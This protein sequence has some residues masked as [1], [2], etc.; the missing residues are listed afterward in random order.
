MKLATF[1]IEEHLFGVD[2]LLTREICPLQQMTQI[3]KAPE[4]IKGLM[5][6]RGQIITVIDP[7]PFLYR[8]DNQTH[9]DTQLLI[10]AGNE[11]IEQ[12]KKRQLVEDVELAG[13]PFAF[14]IDRI[15]NVIDLSEDRV[16]PAPASLDTLDRDLVQGVVE[17]GDDLVILLDMSQFVKR[18]L[19]V[20]ESGSR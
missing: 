8:K 3:A 20:S 19:S 16:L 5:N 12:L 17:E 2:L 18:I 1:Y 6:L 15:A 9:E 14:L 11:E 7:G 13:D 10:F 4:H